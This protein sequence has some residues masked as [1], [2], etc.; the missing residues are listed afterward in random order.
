MATAGHGSSISML[1][2]NDHEQ[3][4]AAADRDQLQSDDW[5]LL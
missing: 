5:L 2:W 3:R 1:K 4:A